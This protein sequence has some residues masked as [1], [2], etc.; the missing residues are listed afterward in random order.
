M[1]VQQ[2]PEHKTPKDYLAG[3]TKWLLANNI[4]PIARSYG[5]EFTNIELA[6]GVAATCSADFH[7][8]AVAAE[9]NCHLSGS[10]P[11]AVT[12]WVNE[13]CQ[14]SGLT[15]KEHRRQIRRT[16][17]RVSTAQFPDLLGKLRADRKAVNEINTLPMTGPY[18]VN[19]WQIA[20]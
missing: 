6:I 11:Q 20:E 5:R 2:T 19:V 1:D 8:T 15:V 12:R 17:T 7:G 13:L 10:P 16:Q 18:Q 4:V 3:A 14:A 9:F